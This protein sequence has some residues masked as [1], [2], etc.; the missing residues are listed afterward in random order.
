MQLSNQIMLHDLKGILFDCLKN[1]LAFSHKIPMTSQV[2]HEVAMGQGQ[3]EVALEKLH[4]AAEKGEWLCLKNLHLMTFW[5]PVLE[6]EVQAL[7][8]H[9]NFRLW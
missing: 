1:V 3:T 9:E 7:N 4:L 2:L 5:L 8:Q 6:K